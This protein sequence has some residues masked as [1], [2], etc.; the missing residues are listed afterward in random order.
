MGRFCSQLVEEE[1]D[2]AILSNYR[3]VYYL[4][5]HLREVESPQ[6]L[7]VTPEGSSIL[8]TDVLPTQTI[9]DEVLAYENYSIDWPV[10]FE[11]VCV[12]AAE[13]LRKAIK[14]LRRRVYRVAVEPS[15][16]NNLFAEVLRDCWPE[17]EL[18]EA[19]RILS[20][21]RRK[22]DQDEINLIIQCIQVIEAGFKAAREVIR[23]GITE[24]EVFEAVHGKIIQKAGYNLKFDGDFAC[25]VRAIKE[26][27]SPLRREILPGDL[28][29]IDIYPSF[30]GYYGD[31]CRTFAVSEAT[32]LQREAWQMISDAL[33][34]AESLIRPGVRASAVY[35]LIRA[36]ID[37]FAIAR[38]SFSH[39]AGHG[40]GLDPQEPP[41]I[42]PGSDHVFEVGDV[43]AMEPA[44]YS[45]A[46]QGGVRLE[47]NYVVHEEGVENLSHSSLGL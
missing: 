24:L 36:R 32:L 22:K 35:N 10:S 17:A 34:F 46:L 47:R 6:L 8:I 30:Y 29:I 1:I 42:I 18:S 11:A 26:C 31:L 9:A 44:C 25:G 12:K 23:P 27:G 4:S 14:G 20:K 38:G 16:F 41:W 2:L 39:H 21:L 28:Y 15:R 43:I 40:I 7:I 37:S 45:P 33:T 19:T 5:G 3:N 13:V